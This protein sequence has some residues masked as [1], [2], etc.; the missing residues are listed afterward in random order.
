[1]TT[2]VGGVTEV[3]PNNMVSF[4]EPNPADIINKLK[5]AIPIAKNIPTHQFH[6]RV[7]NMYNWKNVASRNVLLFLLLVCSL[8]ESN[9]D[10]AD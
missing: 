2:N 6:E 4:A 8:I 9:G 3:L 7:K 5:H 10:C 1:V